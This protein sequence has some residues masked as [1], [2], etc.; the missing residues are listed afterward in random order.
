MPAARQFGFTLLE[1]LVVFAIVGILLGAV[2]LGFT[3]IDAE[4]AMR[5][6]AERIATRIEL[7]RQY[8]LQRNKEWGVYVEEAD[9]RFA[10]FDPIQGT[11]VVQAHR[12]FLADAII[13][14]LSFR[15]VTEGLDLDQFGAGEDDL[16]DII[17]FSSGEITPFEWFVEPDW[18]SLAWTVSSDGLTRVTVA[19]DE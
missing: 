9:Y 1:L 4:Q 2:V 16:P 7:A 18:D 5:G 12:P 3:G 6:T 11:W 15:V 8:A 14:R 19:R 17:A 13:D 10:E